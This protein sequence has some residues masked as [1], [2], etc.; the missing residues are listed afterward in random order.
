MG[1]TRRSFLRALA[2]TAAGST[3]LSGHARAAPRRGAGKVVVI[4]G[5]FAGATAAKYL[6]LWAPQIEVTLVEPNARFVSCPVS[7]RVIGG[8][9]ELAVL[10]VA[11]ERLQRERGVRIVPARASAIDPARREVRLADGQRLPYDRVIVAPGIELVYDDLPGLRSAAAQERVPHAWKAGAQTIALRKQLEAMRNGGVYAICIPRSP[12]RCAPAPYERACQV[13]FYFKSHK[14]RSK[15]LVLDANEDIQSKKAL[16][17]AAWSGRYK[18]IVEYRPNSELADVDLS[19][20]TAKLLFEDVK[21]DVLNVIPPNRAGEIARTAGLITTNDRWCAVEWRT[22]ESSA[23]PGVH[24]LGDSTLSAPAMPKSGHM[25]NQHG[26]LAADAVIALL[27]GRAVNEEPILSSACYSWIS[28]R[29]VVHV[30]SLHRYDPAEKTLM[31]VEGAGGLSPSISSAEAPYA[32][33][34]LRNILADTLS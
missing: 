34:W 24:V 11:Y 33:G 13:A 21:A 17:T 16:F 1:M 5:G 28:D 7:N 32:M 3:G 15:I 20:R 14:P 26:K 8:N 9:L 2:G 10:T 23:V 27:T 30:A 12:Y 19:T 31:P 22:M 6:R 29:E 4:G 18:G 25:A